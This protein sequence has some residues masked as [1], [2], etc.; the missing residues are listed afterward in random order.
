MSPTARVEAGYLLRPLQEGMNL[1]LPHSR[2][3]PSIG[4][5]CYELRIQVNQEK[6]KQLANKGCTATTVEDFLGLTPEE[7]AYVELKL[8]L[9]QSL[10]ERRQSLYLTQ[11][12]LAQKIESSQSRVS[13]MEI[14]DPSVSIDL[15]IRSLLSLGVTKE[16][17]GRI[18]TN[19]IAIQATK[20]VPARVNEETGPK[21]R[22]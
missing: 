15:L 7:S 21:Q 1:S 13:K 17:I 6:Q 9:S 8:L 3:I 14:G 11:E 2:P 16:E 4:N 22:E 18:I 10:K 5:R 12:A 20:G 19:N